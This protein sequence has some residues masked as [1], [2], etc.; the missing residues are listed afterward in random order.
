MG[1]ALGTRCASGT[2]DCSVQYVVEDVY[3]MLFTCLLY[4]ADK[5]VQL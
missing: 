1:V 2:S 4:V 5:Y 3:S